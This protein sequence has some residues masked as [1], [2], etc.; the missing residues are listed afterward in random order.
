[1]R[2]LLANFPGMTF[3]VIIGLVIGSLAVVFPGVPASG[4]MWILSIVAFI[5]GVIVVRLL[6]KYSV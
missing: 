3:S 1:I 4:V 6:S 2:Y 5:A